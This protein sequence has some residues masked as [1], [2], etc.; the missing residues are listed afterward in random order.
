VQVGQSPVFRRPVGMIEDR[1]QVSRNTLQLNR[2]DGTFAE[3]AFWSGVEASDWS[4]CVGF[5]DVDLDG[6][7]D[8]L[9][10]NG[11]YHD[12]Q[13]AD[14]AARIDSERGAGRLMREKL[15]ERFLE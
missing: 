12:M 10:T 14:A 13:N 1:P 2:G 8:I 9:V 4:W 11:H 3:V 6:Y 5:L 7:E 15:F